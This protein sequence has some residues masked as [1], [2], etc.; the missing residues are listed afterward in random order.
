MKKANGAGNH[1]LSWAAALAMTPEM[2]RR[3]RDWSET[4]LQFLI[5]LKKLENAL[6]G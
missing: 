4:M 2:R 6:V 5:E 3:L 1:T